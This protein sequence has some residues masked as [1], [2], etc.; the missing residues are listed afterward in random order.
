[1]E[2]CGI[3][4]CLFLRSGILGIIA[5]AARLMSFKICLRTIGRRFTGRMNF[6][7]R[8]LWIFENSALLGAKFHGIRVRKLR[9]YDYI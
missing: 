4:L 1:M 8:L 3:G 6:C 9:V 5:I 2:V 7:Q